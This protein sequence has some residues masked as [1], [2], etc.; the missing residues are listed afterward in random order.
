MTPVDPGIE[1]PSRIARLPTDRGFPVP[2]FVAWIDG[3]PDFRVIAPG[4]V[5]EAVNKGKCWVC[6]GTLFGTR[7]YVV[8]P[9]CAVNRTS[10]EPPSHRDCARY[11]AKA[12]PFLSRPTMRRRDAGHARG[13]QPRRT[14]RAS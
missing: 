3:K 1:M 4:R 12:C 11:S 2:W 13:R 9:M 5:A 10:A 7:A 6:G 8:G 14:C